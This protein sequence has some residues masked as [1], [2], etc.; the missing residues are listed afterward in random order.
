MCGG[1]LIAAEGNS[2]ATCDSCGS[3]QTLPSMADEQKANLFNRANHLRRSNDFDRA[4]SAYENILN[5]D[6]RNAEAHWGLLL[7]RYGIEYVEDPRTHEM[8]PTCHRVQRDSI[9]ADSD[10]KATLEYAPDYN[11]KQLYEEEAGKIA[12]IQRDILALSSREEPYDVFICYKETSDAGTRTRD[13]ALAQDIYY[14]LTKEGYK[15]FFSRITLE[16]KLGQ[17]YEP[18]IF[19]ALHSAKVMLVI[20]TKPEYFR[21]IW[22]KNEWSR[23]LALMKKDRSKLLIPCYQGMDPYDLPDEMSM[24]QS[25]DMSR[26]GFIQDLLHGVEKVVRVVKPK[27]F[28]PVLTEPATVTVNIDSLY[29]RACIFQ[30]D[31]DWKQADEY[32]DRILDQEPE[33]APAYIGKLCV[34][35]HIKKERD[36]STLMSSITENK[37]FI[38][39]MRFA[40]SRQK[41]IYRGYERAFQNNIQE[42]INKI[43]EQEVNHLLDIKRQL[44]MEQ[45]DSLNSDQMR[46]L[47]KLNG[48]KERINSELGELNREKEYEQKKL[49]SLGFFDFSGKSAVNNAIGQIER[50]LKTM[51][52]E[53][54]KIEFKIAEIQK[55]KSIE[56]SMIKPIHFGNHDWI[57]LATGN[58]R[59]LLITKDIVILRP[60]NKAL[61]DITWEKC[62]LRTY[63]NSEFI[64]QTFH[65]DFERSLILENLNKNPSNPQFHTDGGNDT[66]D[67]IFLLSIEEAKQYFKTD[68]ERMAYWKGNPTWWWLRS[69]GNDNLSAAYVRTDGSVYLDGP[70]VNSDRGVRPAFWLNLKT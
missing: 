33:Y 23:Y 70:Y 44:G 31:G 49:D 11:S 43:R 1:E 63:L 64:N 48:I 4:V 65:S 12:Q 41:E 58:T 47:E 56:K 18:Y 66:A 67:K 69:P 57:V 2:I 16:S 17:Q 40:N 36:L 54:N 15:V 26:I 28:E 10:Y 34:E 32:F 30:E 51:L 5:L 50:Q 13:S 25:Q 55:P 19:A 45:P 53:Y 42:K 38:K 62:T 22:V 20:G 52:A 8:L 39:A 29:K 46:E 61:E 6:D 24:L 60:Y 68:R 3:R 21:A 59:A 35:L 27:S 14:S 9:L 7:S 37:N